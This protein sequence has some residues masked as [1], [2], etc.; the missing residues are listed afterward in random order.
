MKTSKIWTNKNSQLFNIV[1]D[2]DINLWSNE[3]N[4][5]FSYFFFVKL[6]KIPDSEIYLLNRWT[7]H[8]SYS[9]NLSVSNLCFKK[10]S[11]YTQQILICTF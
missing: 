11:I 10:P 7:G 6:N 5:D 8:V 9:H 2:F 4:I 3:Q 1:I